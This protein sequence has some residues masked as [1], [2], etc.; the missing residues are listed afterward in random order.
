MLG[1]VGTL[2]GDARPGAGSDGVRL[3]EEGDGP[4]LRSTRAPC[5]AQPAD[6][7]TC[8]LA[9]GAGL[10]ARR[11]P[12]GVAERRTAGWGRNVVTPRVLAADSTCSTKRS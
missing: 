4:M 2:G 3:P 8:A 5:R 9:Q 10:G 6:A 7:G 1:E 12:G 11:G